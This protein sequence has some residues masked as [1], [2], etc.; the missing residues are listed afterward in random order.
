MQIEECFRD[1]KAHRHGWALDYVR[2]NS[3]Q[4][5]EILVLLA[6]FGLVGMHT[7]GLAA[8]RAKLHLG[9]QANTVR[10]RRVLST[11]SLARLLIRDRRASW[12]KPD[13]IRS[14]VADLQA[15]IRSASEAA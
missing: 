1:L 4:R 10:N 6:A 8:E 7:L 5:V 15:T 13:Q 14:G 2:S 12:L 11:F 3:P 9:Y